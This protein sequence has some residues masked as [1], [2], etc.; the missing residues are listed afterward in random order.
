MG[1][2]IALFKG[3]KNLCTDFGQI[4]GGKRG[5]YSRGEH[6]IKK[7]R[8]SKYVIKYLKLNKRNDFRQH[9]WPA[10][11]DLPH[12]KRTTTKAA[13]YGSSKGWHKVLWIKKTNKKGITELI[14]MG[15]Q[16]KVNLIFQGFYQF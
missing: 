14:K 5:N 11:M 7:I 12:S 8:Y 6:T 10:R 4:F 15:F 16:E 1:K 9:A 3:L 2:L 13:A